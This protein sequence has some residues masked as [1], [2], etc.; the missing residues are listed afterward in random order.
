MP[1][2]TVERFLAA[3]RQADHRRL[4]VACSGG[5]DSVCLLDILVSLQAEHGLPLYVVHVHHGLNPRADDWAERV[6][7]LADDYK[8][9][10]GTLRVSVPDSGSL[11]EGARKAR[12]EAIGR[13]LQPGD[14]LLTGHHRQDQAETLLLQLLRGSGAAGLAAMRPV[15]Q[16]PFSRPDMPLWRPLLD[17]PRAILLA[18][19][20]SRGLT[21]VEDDSNTDVRHNRNF[22]RARV[23]PLLEQ[24]WPDA[25][26]GLARTA[27]RMRESDQLLTDLAELD[28]RSAGGMDDSLLISAILTLSPPRQ[29]NLLYFWIRRSGLPV[30]DRAGLQ[31]LVEE[32]CLARPDG[33]PRFVWRQLEIRRYRDRLFLQVTGEKDAGKCLPIS[34]LDRMSPLNLPDGRVLTPRFDSDT[35]VKRQVWAGVSHLQI[36]FRQGGEEIQLPGRGRKTLKALFQE[37]GIPPW[38]RE[39]WPLVY[40][41]GQLLMV[42]GL[43]VD[44]LA[45]GKS[46]EDMVW[47]T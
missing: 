19:A 29:A 4:I 13:I 31:K 11:E 26:R 40:G 47:I 1:R 10:H 8:L 42:P 43:W 21:W 46:G 16:V 20:Q 28:W 27:E 33:E 45:A 30:P 25:A 2:S 34:W 24:R 5:L 36:R 9:P 6:S 14:V 3:R 17:I 12:Y 18:Y 23:M 32:V 7:R 22:I 37:A 35:G 38:K 39:V 41:D 44:V 15:A